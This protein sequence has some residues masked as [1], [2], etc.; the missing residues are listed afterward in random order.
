MDQYEDSKHS[1]SHDRECV[2]IPSPPAHCFRNPRDQC[3]DE[4][5]S[6][7]EAQREAVVVKTGSEENL[8]EQDQSKDRQRQGQ[9]VLG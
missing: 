9:D 6:T 3:N 4:H 5:E 7:W 1:K 2:S 8:G